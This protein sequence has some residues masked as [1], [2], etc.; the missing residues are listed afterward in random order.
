MN[1][2]YAIDFLAEICSEY[3]HR[4]FLVWIVVT[5]LTEVH[6]VVPADI[7]TTW[8]MREISSH[9]VFFK[10]VVTC[11]NRC[12]CREQSR[13]SDKFLSDVEVKVMT[14]DVD[15][16]SLQSAECS[17]TFVA[18]IDSR[19]DVNLIHQSDTADAEEHLLFDT[20][21]AVAAIELT[22]DASVFW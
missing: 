1:L 17:V 15:A 3:A 10:H 13:C 11:W 4:E 8:I 12:V 7:H 16:Q 9:K 2:T 20:H 14:C 22:G 21:L 5:Y 18:V 6:E 19:F